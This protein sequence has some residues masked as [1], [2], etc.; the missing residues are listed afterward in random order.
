[1][2]SKNKE[3]KII[4]KLLL[5]GFLT[6]IVRIIG[7]L[8]IPSGTQSVLKPSA[9]VINGTMPMAFTVYGI[10]AYMIV[11][12]M[13]LLVK[14]KI[15]GNGV[16]KGLKYAS[17]CCAIWVAY[18]L[19][20]LPHVAFIDKFTYPIADSIALL[21]LG[22]F[23]GVFLCKREE[24]DDKITFRINICSTL[25]IVLFFFVG[26]II[27][28][29]IIGI[30]SSYGDNKIGS[31]IWA[32]FVG[33]V[34]SIVLQWLNDKLIVEKPI[35]RQLILG[36]V[37]FGVDLSVFNFFMPLVFDT[38]ILDLIIRTGVDFCFATIGCFFVGVKNGKN[39]EK[40]N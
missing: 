19:E 27:L 16:I 6:T 29:E 17:S 2:R 31:I 32:V 15:C 5:I 20:P 24:A 10:F 9:F 1:M 37:L 35:V 4:I 22:I 33:T 25:A 23:V 12:S 21:A 28:Y 18:L 26:R 13:F 14:D 3:F 34:I 40:C 8:F 7:Q 38:D 30:Y 11:A 36:M 39:K